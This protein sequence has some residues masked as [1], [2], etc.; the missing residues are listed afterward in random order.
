MTN[1]RPALIDDDRLRLNAFIN[2]CQKCALLAADREQFPTCLGEALA[3]VPPCATAD[4]LMVVETTLWRLLMRA[5]SGSA[6]PELVTSREAGLLFARGRIR[7]AF[8][9]ML[10]APRR[11]TTPASGGVWDDNRI[12]HAWRYLKEHANDPNVNL[13]SVAR[14][15]NLS[16][17]HF[18]RLLKRGTGAGFRQFLARA[19][20]E[21]ARTLLL[22]TSL[23]V[24]EIAAQVGYKHSSELTRQFKEYLETTPTTLRRGDRRVGSIAISAD[25]AARA[26]AR[27]SIAPRAMCPDRE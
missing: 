22:T 24:K 14:H 5:V 27:G 12:R 18:D 23:Q 6:V 10:A 21:R 26:S 19:R 25:R 16:K 1:T 15:V 20:I 17:W 3:L 4:V 11:S 2:Q 13:H 7:E 8:Q 9:A